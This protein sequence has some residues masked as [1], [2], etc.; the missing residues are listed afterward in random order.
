M[1]NK[2]GKSS[3]SST[4]QSI[5]SLISMK[6]KKST[7]KP[8]DDELENIK[9]IHKTLKEKF[10]SLFSTSDIVHWYLGIYKILNMVIVINL[11]FF[12]FLYFWSQSGRK[13]KEMEKSYLP[14]NF[15]S[16]TNNKFCTWLKI[17]VYF[18]KT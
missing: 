10:F 4:I 1:N 13:M 16:Q 17:G 14:E 7:K 12:S 5:L 8:V 15:S 2:C 6:H 18:L 3:P 11:L 9:N